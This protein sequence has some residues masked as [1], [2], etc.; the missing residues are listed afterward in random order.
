MSA[1]TW[2][3]AAALGAGPKNELV[4]SPNVSALSD[5]FAGVGGTDEVSY[6]FSNAGTAGASSYTV[7][8]PTSFTWLLIGAAGDY[9]IYLDSTG[10]PDPISSGDSVNTWLSLGTSRTWTLSATN[11]ASTFSGNYT[12]RRISDSVVVGAGTFTLN[13]DSAP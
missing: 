1:L 7:A 11:T 9:E 13:V 6:S 3:L 2:I 4:Y 5:T 12:I 8:S 10:T